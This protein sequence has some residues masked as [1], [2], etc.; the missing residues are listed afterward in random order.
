LYELK[1]NICEAVISV[2]VSELFS[3]SMFIM[4]SI[5]AANLDP[6]FLAGYV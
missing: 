4:L 3:I 6:D 1:H 2:G 5:L